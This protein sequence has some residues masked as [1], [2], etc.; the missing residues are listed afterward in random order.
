MEKIRKK[1]EKMQDINTKIKILSRAVMN[2]CDIKNYFDCSISKARRIKK[3]ALDEANGAVKWS[4][5][6]VRT[7]AVLSL[8]GTTRLKE[9]AVLRLIR[10][11]AERSGEEYE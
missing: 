7:D 5:N 2:V 4:V 11:N 8:Y 10:N 1:G 6:E 3:R 9:L